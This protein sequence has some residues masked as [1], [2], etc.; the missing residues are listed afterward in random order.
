MRN[1]R[2]IPEERRARAEVEGRDSS[3]PC[4]LAF[5][6][7]PALRAAACWVEEDK[8]RKRKEK[9]KRAKGRGGEGRGEGGPG[10][11]QEVQVS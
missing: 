10:L 3:E 4:M 6:A 2:Y 5:P 1:S 9:K 11:W 8:Q 7:G